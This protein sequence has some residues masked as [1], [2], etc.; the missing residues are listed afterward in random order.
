MSNNK[1]RNLNELNREELI[2]VVENKKRKSIENKKIIKELKGNNE[3]LQE[4]NDEYK[5]DIENSDISYCEYGKHYTGNRIGYQCD[6]CCNQ[7]D[8]CIGCSESH[9]CKRRCIEC[10]KKKN[11]EK[12]D[13]CNKCNP[14]DVCFSCVEKHKNETHKEFKIK[15]IDMDNPSSSQYTLKVDWTYE[16]GYINDRLWDKTFNKKV[17]HISD[18]NK[19]VDDK[20][21]GEYEKIREEH[22]FEAIIYLNDKRLDNNRLIKEYNEIT[23]DTI[24]HFKNII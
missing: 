7:K 8:M 3:K 21:F 11:S 5:R 12:F 24:L 19:N 4:S 1:K 20:D 17:K 23:Q 13:C 18:E 22:E 15:L 10:K 9:E 6:D 2:L 14:S 16:I